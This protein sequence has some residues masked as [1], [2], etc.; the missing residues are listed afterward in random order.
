MSGAE[1]KPRNRKWNLWRA[2][3]YGFILQVLIF[4]FHVSVV[5]DEQL[6]GLTADELGYFFG[7]MLPCPTFFIVVA[8]VRNFF[9]RESVQ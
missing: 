6:P 7:L 3:L 4:S 2:A 9:V 8:F 5:G 1:N